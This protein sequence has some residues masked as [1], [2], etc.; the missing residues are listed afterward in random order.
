MTNVALLFGLAAMV[1]WGIWALL[2]DVATDYV[3]PV[4]AMIFSYATSVAVALAYVVAREDSLS[5]VR[6]GVG[7]ALVAGVFAGIGAV[8]FY[9]GL[10][11]GQTSIVTT[12]SA[13]YFV[14]AAVLGVVVLGESV[15]LE[16]VAGI[17]FAVAAVTLLAR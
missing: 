7:F 12:V 13:L 4:S 5:T 15:G 6:T 9:S 11:R 10:E 2:A 1:S 17:A 8:A 14:V 16:D 3:D